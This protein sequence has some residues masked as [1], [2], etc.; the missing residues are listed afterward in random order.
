MMQI[1]LIGIYFGRK[2]FQLQFRLKKAPTYCKL[3]GPNR[4][5]L[6]QLLGG[7]STGH[8]LPQLRIAQDHPED[9]VEL[10]LVKNSLR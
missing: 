4:R 7:G 6:V 5:E 1:K 8:H 3:S 2:S 10:G 9:L